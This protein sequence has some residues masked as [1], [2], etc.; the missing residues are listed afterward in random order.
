MPLVVDIVIDR[1]VVGRLQDKNGDN[2]Q[3]IP[4]KLSSHCIHALIRGL[5]SALSVYLNPNSVTLLD[6]P[7][8]LNFMLNTLN[9]F[10]YS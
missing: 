5:K 6:P 7:K 1:M 4:T 3:K 9:Q 8:K 10:Q 2:I